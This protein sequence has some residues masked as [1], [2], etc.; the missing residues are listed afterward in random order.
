MGIEIDSIL[1]M[2]QKWN[3]VEQS[4]TKWNA[5]KVKSGTDLNHFVPPVRDIVNVEISTE[6]LPASFQKN[7]TNQFSFV[8]P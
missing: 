4:G 7:G 1:K 6:T 5:A 3:K 2:E 8:P